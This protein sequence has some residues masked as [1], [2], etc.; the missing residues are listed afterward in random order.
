MASPTNTTEPARE[1]ILRDFP[2]EI[3]DIAEQLRRMVKDLVPDAFEKAYPRWRGIG[4]RHP[5]AGYFCGIFPQRDEVR[6]L[7]EWGVLLSDPDGLLIGDGRQVRYV[8]VTDIATVDRPGITALIS[9]ALA[10][11][12]SAAVKRQ[13]LQNNVR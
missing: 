1:D 7:F 3:R 12:E 13:L 9:A 8:P 10:L 2:L 5:A 4:Y 11:P 6:L